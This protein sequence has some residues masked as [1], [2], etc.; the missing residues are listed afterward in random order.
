M[1]LVAGIDALNTPDLFATANRR[2]ILHAAVYGAFAKSGAH[3]NGLETAIQKPG[4]KHLD[5]IAVEP[6]HDAGWTPS[7][8]NALRF[9]ISTQGVTDEV[10]SSHQFLME[11]A[12]RHPDRIRL[13]TAHRL[14]CLPILVADDTIVFG[15][16]AHARL[17]APHGF[18][19]M[20]KTDVEKLL[21]WAGTGRTPAWATVEEIA[22]FRL[23]NECVRAMTNTSNPAQICIP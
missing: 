12:A 17:H 20:V 1:K 4:F 18:W 22:A 11:L 3:R 8:L 23:I 19:G 2:I 9:G 7:F 14:P 16:Y 10:L 21:E 6:G 13:H 15:Q 5:I